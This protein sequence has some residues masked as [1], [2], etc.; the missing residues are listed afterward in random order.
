[1]KEFI[2][3]LIERLREESYFVRPRGRSESE[4][5]VEINEA[6]SIINK[7]AEEYKHCTLC[8]LQSPCEYQNENVMLPNELLADENGWI[9]CSE[10]LPSKEECGTY[11]RKEF[12]VTIPQADGNET[13][14]MEFV[15]EKVRGE[16]VGR[17]KWKGGLSPWKVL[18]WKHLDAPYTKGE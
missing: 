1:M 11:R 2:D 17:W 13:T 8:Y 4:T 6:I 15:Y 14:T 9:S 12:Q 5:V 7:L 3:K 10:R 16:E 18:A